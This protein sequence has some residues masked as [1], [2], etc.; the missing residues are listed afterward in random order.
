MNND[1][2]RGQETVN[3]ELKVCLYERDGW[4]YDKKRERGV[5]VAV[6]TEQ[7]QSGLTSDEGWGEGV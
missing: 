1:V 5:M 2:R 7:V 4:G 3:K 6:S